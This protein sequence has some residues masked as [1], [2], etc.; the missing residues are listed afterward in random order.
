[1]YYPSAPLRALQSLGVKL[2]FADG[3]DHKAA[4]KL[5]AGSDVAVVFVT[6]WTGESVDKPL[7]LPDGQDALVSAIARVNPRTVVV[8]ETGGA[9]FM[10]WIDEVQ[11][12]LQAWYPGTSGGEAIANVLTG[13]VNPSG[14]LPISFPR[15]E[16]QFARAALEEHDAQ[17]SKSGQANYREG[18]TV[19]Y[20]WFDARHLQ[21]LFPF[22]FGL[23]YTKFEYGGL[24]A[25]LEDGERVVSFEVRK[26]GAREG[27]EV[28]QVYVS[29]VAGGWEAPRRLGGWRKVDL[30]PGAGAT[31]SVR[32]DPRLLGV[33]HEAERTWRIE[34]GEYSIQLGHSAADLAPGTKVTLPIRELPVGFQP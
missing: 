22:G 30:E 6:Q 7:T 26:T 12:V 1:M 8:L 28:P 19:G 29:P 10:P 34:A 17:G 4:A 31:L 15:D 14:H 25:R 20:K 33:F 13:R 16:S 27:A 23:S 2:R 11:G 21:P 9:V 24:R 18:A 3:K 5:A 32:I